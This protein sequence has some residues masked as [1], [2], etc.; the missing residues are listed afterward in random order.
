MTYIYGVFI[1]DEKLDQKSSLFLGSF[2]WN[3]RIPA[4]NI[5]WICF[6]VRSMSCWWPWTTQND[7]NKEWTR[8]KSTSFCSHMF[9]CIAFTRIFFKIISKRKNDESSWELNG[10]WNDV[11]HR[12]NGKF[13]NFKIEKSKNFRHCQYHHC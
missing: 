5:S 10:L 3:E 12:W 4:K 11:T 9:Q 2:W 8:L 13:P 6:W 1:F 7:F